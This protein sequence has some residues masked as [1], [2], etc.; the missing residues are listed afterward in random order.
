M[1]WNYRIVRYRSGEGYGLHEVFCNEVGEP[2]AMGEHPAGFV[3]H[4]DEGP[5]AVQEALRMAGTDARLRPILDEPEQWASPPEGGRN[6][7]P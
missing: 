4:F 1:T 5:G 7:E 6:D 2:Y 3:A